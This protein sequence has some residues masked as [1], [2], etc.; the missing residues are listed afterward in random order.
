MHP[1]I[2]ATVPLINTTIMF[3]I[4]QCYRK[5]CARLSVLSGSHQTGTP[6]IRWGTAA[7]V[8]WV[9]LGWNRTL[10][11]MLATLRDHVHSEAAGVPPC[12]AEA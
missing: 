4:M 5:F 2:H 1:Y 10:K 6:T 11:W 9:G 3:A 7:G 8:A 12:S